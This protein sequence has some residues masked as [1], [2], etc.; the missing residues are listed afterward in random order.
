MGFSVSLYKFDKRV[1]STKQPDANTPVLATSC[2]LKTSCSL[3]QPVITFDSASFSSGG[4]LTTPTE[5]TYAYIQEFG[6]YYWITNWTWG[7]GIW[8][9]SL[10]CDV[11]ASFKTDIGNSRQY[12]LR[13]ATS[14]NP[15]IVDTKYLTYYDHSVTCTD[16]QSVSSIWSTGI[17][18]A[19][20]AS[21]FFVIGI[22]NNDTSAVGATSYYAMAGS[23]ARKFISKLMAAPTWLG[24]TDATLTTDL[25]K[26]MFN[27]MEYISSL[28]WIPYGLPSYSTRTPIHSVPLGWWSLD[29]DN[30]D[31]IYR[32][33]GSDLT[34]I[35]VDAYINVPTH[36][37][38]TGNRRYLNL[39]PYSSYS[40]TFEP[41]GTFPL[42]PTKIYGAYRL[43][44]RVELDVI[45]GRG[46]LG[47][48]A[49]YHDVADPSVTR[50]SAE[51][52]T[53]I[54]QVGIPI[55]TAALTVDRSSITSAGTWVMGAGLTLA[56]NHGEWLNSQIGAVESVVN[57]VADVA[58]GRSS[59][60]WKTAAPM[61]AAGLVGG[62]GAAKAVGEW[63]T[64]QTYEEAL[65]A[66]GISSE[67]FISD[68]SRAGIVDT[69]KQDFSDIMNAVIGSSGSCQSQGLTGGFAMYDFPIYCRIYYTAIVPE[70]NDRWG[71]PLCA[72][73]YIR[74]HSGYVLCATGEVNVN[75]TK[76]ER[77]DI[78]AYLTGG[79]YYE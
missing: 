54:A 43:R 22:V 3:L 60:N 42:D 8:S 2:E 39:A 31:D 7:N 75:A 64:G 41:F 71:R 16:Q 38:A 27:P 29:M 79:F 59:L 55:S 19:T 68:N 74:N 33:S 73:D 12:I 57:T 30:T 24:V 45:T 63:I 25:Q 56:Q 53:T 77:Q 72:T 21:G 10:I 51:I 20:P 17:N 70:N 36:P 4:Q 1:N 78:M 18:A 28:T 62:A 35:S 32:L 61:L 6:R 65:E 26:L 9:A 49:E 69:I 14:C 34:G 37:Q 67:P 52:F 23:V 11:L 5:Y 76:P 40:L 46:R 58:S 48:F 47:V 15:D 50:T 44:L 66:R 13:S